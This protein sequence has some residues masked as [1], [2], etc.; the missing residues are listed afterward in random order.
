MVTNNEKGTAIIIVLVILMSVTILGLSSMSITGYDHMITGNFKRHKTTFSYT[1]GSVMASTAV[2]SESIRQNKVPDAL[3]TSGFFTA[4]TASA[5]FNQIEGFDAYDSAPD[6]STASP[7]GAVTTT[8]D[9]QRLG[10]KAMPGSSIEFGTSGSGFQP[11][12]YVSYLATATG[13]G[14]I[15]SQSNI[16]VVYYKPVM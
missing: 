13:S 6:M 14:A 16:R 8:V 3:V 1:D 12:S 10:A 4:E 9:V 11:G 5:F 15:Q 2:I 7:D